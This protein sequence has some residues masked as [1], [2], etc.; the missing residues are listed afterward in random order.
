MIFPQKLDYFFGAAQPWQKKW[1]GKQ[2]TFDSMRAFSPGQ[3]TPKGRKLEK[4]S[5]NNRSFYHEINGNCL[6]LAFTQ[7]YTFF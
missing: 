3:L 6:L 5:S 4:N 1:I 2:I 7:C